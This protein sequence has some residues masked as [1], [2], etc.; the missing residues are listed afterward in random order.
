MLNY[1]P[2]MIAPKY[3]VRLDDLTPM[4]GIEITCPRCDHIG[5][6]P[7]STL[8]KRH[9]AN[10]RILIIED[11]FI[12][13]KCGNKKGNEWQTVRERLVFKLRA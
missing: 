12:C 10:I 1:D 13:G 9:K 6:V 4:D 8:R 5:I 11:E 7:L 3:A 2:I